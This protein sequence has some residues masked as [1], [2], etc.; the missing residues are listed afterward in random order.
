MCNQHLL[1]IVAAVVVFI[2]IIIIIIK[3]NAFAFLVNIVVLLS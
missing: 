1:V 3:V 2:V